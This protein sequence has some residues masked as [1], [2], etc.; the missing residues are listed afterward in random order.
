MSHGHSIASASLESGER[1]DLLIHALAQLPDEVTLELCGEGP[2]LSRL[3]LLAR[4]YAISERVRSTIQGKPNGGTFIHPSLA[5]GAE[6]ALHGR[7]SLTVDVSDEAPSEAAVADTLAEL[8][9][10][11]GRPDAPPASVRASDELFAGE[12]IVVVTNVPAPYRVELFARVAPRLEAAGARFDVIYQAHA[13][14]SRPWLESAGEPAFRHQF[15]RG[16][17]LPLR[18][19]RPVVPLDLEWTLARLE[20]TLLVCAGFS[21]AVAGRGAIYARRKRI[22]FGIWSGETRAMPT[23]DQWWRQRARRWIVRQASF[24]IAYGFESGEYLASL[25]PSL[26]LVYARNTSHV[27]RGRERP[28]RPDPV[29]ILST[30]DLSSDRKGVDV[31]I[32]ALRLAPELPCELTIVGGGRLFGSLVER[33]RGDA[34]IRFLGPVAYDEAISQYGQADIYAFPT[35]RDVYGLVMVEA[36]GSGLAT[37]VSTAPGALGDLAVSGSNCL[38]IDGHRPQDWADALE[39][40]IREHDLRR[41]LAARGRATITRRWTME[42]SA[43]A[44]IAGLRLGLLTRE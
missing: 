28:E 20:P 13:P 24:A 10:R 16:Y 6:F 8:V 22:P 27:D 19:R 12:R 25:D 42:H 44:M 17:E 30:A 39:R 38:V 1:L 9:E 7:G 37:V 35:R 36:M 41:S 2:Y 29:R 26:P 23:A 33:A 21:P 5:S 31:L 40:L 15:L 34:R 14:T 3:E 32:D 43:D 11:L 4:A 18:E